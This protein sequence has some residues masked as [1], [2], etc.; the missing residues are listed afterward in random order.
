[1]FLL[2]FVIR[3]NQLTK[4]NTY[5]IFGYGC[6]IVML[7]VVFIER[8]F[9]LASLFLLLGLRRVLSL[10]S[11]K[12]LEKKILDASLWIGVATLFYFWS[13][14]FYAVLFV[15]I[16]QQK[17]TTYKHLIIPLLGIL[18]VASLAT[19][20]W[21]VF[22]DSYPQWR[23]LK[24]ATAHDFSAYNEWQLLL[25]A[26]ILSTLLLWT[27]GNRIFKLTKIGKK[28][29]PNQYIILLT[30]VATMAIAIAAPTKSGAE[31]FFVFPPLAIVAANY[32]ER[33]K[34]FWFKELLL[35]LLLLLAITILVL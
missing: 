9:I 13:F 22:F 32:F 35:W 14:L 16:L 34:E 8:Y 5:A 12:N 10:T 4:N 7:P 30:L 3:K 1:M 21:L 15:Q 27:A 17:N 20:Y 31:L 28:H 2:D 23:T 29:K 11:E 19:S 26:S 25:P 24:E 18:V 6:F 33:V